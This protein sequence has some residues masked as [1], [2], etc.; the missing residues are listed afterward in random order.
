MPGGHA[1]TNTYADARYADSDADGYTSTDAEAYPNTAAS[2]NTAAEAN[3]VADRLR[4]R[5]KE[6]QSY[7]VVKRELASEPREFLAFRWIG[8]SSRR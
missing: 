6:L 5:L 4:L 1:H 8:V 7:K 3:A 2:W